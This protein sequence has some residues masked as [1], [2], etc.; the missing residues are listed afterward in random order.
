MESLNRRL[1][2]R[3]VAFGLEVKCMRGKIMK[4]KPNRFFRNEFNF[5]NH[6][7]F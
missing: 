1:L 4:Y 2:F 7:D 6:T 5:F 3:V